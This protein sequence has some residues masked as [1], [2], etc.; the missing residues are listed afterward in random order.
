MQQAKLQNTGS[1]KGLGGATGMP[2]VQTEA[3]ALTAHKVE[4]IQDQKTLPSGSANGVIT[5]QSAC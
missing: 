1:F 5:L 3:P 4:C 2:A